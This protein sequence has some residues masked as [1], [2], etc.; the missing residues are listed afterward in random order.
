MRLLEQQKRQE[1]AA[2]E[3]EQQ[4]RGDGDH[5]VVSERARGDLVTSEEG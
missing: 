3:E 1:D 2:V 4:Q 5:V